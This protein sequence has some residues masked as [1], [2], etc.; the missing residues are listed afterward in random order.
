[1]HLDPRK[2]QKQQNEKN[3]ISFV[4]HHNVNNIVNGIHESFESAHS[5][6]AEMETDS[7]KSLDS[8]EVLSCND[9]DDDSL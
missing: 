7:K 1:M 6:A 3:I 2:N 5:S 9:D 4:N 8:D